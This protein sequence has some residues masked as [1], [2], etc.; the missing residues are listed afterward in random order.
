[1]PTEKASFEA[2]K[3]YIPDGSYEWVMPLILQHKVH[4]TVTRE[5][6]TKL[7]DYRHAWAGKNHRISVN[8]NLNR[9]AFLITL[10]HELAHLLAFDQ[11]GHRIAPHGKEWKQVYSGILKVFLE[12][13]LFPE[14]VA[15]ELRAIMHNPPA[16]SCAE[17]N[18]QRILNRYDRKRNGVKLVE[19]LEEGKRFRISNGREFVRGEK[20]RKRIK[21]YELP[22]MK[23]FLFSP[24]YEVQEIL[25]H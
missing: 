19:Q 6:Q 18:L 23:I 2:L 9:Y 11:Y 8:G 14:D 5:R 1:M 12:Q 17:E 22:H 25:S 20:L 3:Q 24:I 4:L 16:S 7:G 13:H 15:T 10:L 21:C